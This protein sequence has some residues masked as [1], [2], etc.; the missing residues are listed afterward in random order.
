M[1][2]IGLFSSKIQ[3]HVRVKFQMKTLR[4]IRLSNEV[5]LGMDHFK[6]SQLTLDFRLY[7]SDNGDLLIVKLVGRKL[8]FLPTIPPLGGGMP[9]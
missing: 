4:K 7:K 6:F 3:L 2:Q 9:P 1:L 8:R 5:K